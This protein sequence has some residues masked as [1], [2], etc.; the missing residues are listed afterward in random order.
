ME[1]EAGG[2]VGDLAE[3]GVARRSGDVGV[4]VARGGRE[5]EEV[6]RGEAGGVK[7]WE[8]LPKVS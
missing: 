7:R 3:G 8:A 2:E 6:S 5:V 4:R 1:G